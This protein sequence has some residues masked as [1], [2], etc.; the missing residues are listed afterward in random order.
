MRRYDGEPTEH[1]E[2]SAK[3]RDPCPAPFLD[4]EVA[5]EASQA[6]AADDDAERNAGAG[7]GD[8]ADLHSGD[9]GP[10]VRHVFDGGPTDRDDGQREGGHEHETP[11]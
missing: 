6:L 3:T 7:R 9:G 11:P 10:V 4:Q 1:D 5:A 2:D 8:V